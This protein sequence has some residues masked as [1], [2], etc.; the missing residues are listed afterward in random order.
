MK[1][2]NR[3]AFNSL[4]ITYYK[5]LCQFAYQYTRN[6]EETEEI[7]SD[8]FFSFWQNKDKINIEQSVKAY[9]YTSVKNA[10]MALVKKRQPLFNDLEDVLNSYAA[11]HHEPD[12]IQEYTE[13]KEYFNRVVDTLPIRCKQIFILNR[14]D[15]L[16]YKEISALLNISE[17]TVENQIVKALM[18]LRSALSKYTIKQY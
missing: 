15:N 3:L 11:R 2:G 9:L 18:V 7:V 14:F 17:K 13:L 12:S 8:V 5:S 10:A 16:K 6:K 4:F 1:Q